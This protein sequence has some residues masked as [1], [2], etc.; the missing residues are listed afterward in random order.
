MAYPYEYF[1]SFDD[2]E[3]SIVNLNKND[4][5][6]KL[7]K[8]IPKEEQIE[9]TNKLID[10][11]NIQIG[12]QLTE[13]YLKTDVILLADAFENVINVSIKEFGINPL[14]SVSLPGFTWQLGLYY[15]DMKLHTLQDKDILLIEYNIRV[16]ISS[17][18]GDKYVISDDKTKISYIDAKKLYGDAM[19]QSLPYADIKFESNIDIDTIIATADDSVIRYF[20]RV[21]LKYPDEIKDK[22]KN[23]PFC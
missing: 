10:I 5:N 17:V 20:V 1:K 23:F 3:L 6:S 18:M 22:T 12:R 2:Y 16:G 15:S 13:L 21:D 11:F 4:D 19:S 7:S 14:Y 8:S 9:R